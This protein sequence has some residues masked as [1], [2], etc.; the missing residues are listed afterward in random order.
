MKN[1]K[2]RDRRSRK[3]RGIN[4]ARALI[5]VTIDLIIAFGLGFCISV[6]LIFQLNLILEAL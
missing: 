6:Y 5:I 4:R 1:L 2:K 3:Y